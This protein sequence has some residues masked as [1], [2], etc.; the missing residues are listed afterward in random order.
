MNN[1][2][3]CLANLTGKERSQYVRQMFMQIAHSYDLMNR[4]ITAGQDVLW[5]QEVI[6]QAALPSYGRLLDLGT[7][8]GDLARE[9]LRQIPSC[10]VTAADFTLEMMNVGRSRTNQD[11]LF[12]VA[13]DAN[14]LPFTAATF[15]AV[16]SGFLLRNVN[17]VRLCLAEQYR[18]LKPGGRIVVLDTTPPPE[19]LLAPA[20]R[21]HLHK[22]I[23]FL[24]RL[25]TGQAE[26]YSYLPDSTE[27]FLQPEQLAVRMQAVG[28]RRVI[29]QRFMFGTV[30]IHWGQ[31]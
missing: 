19:N 6:R 12:W 30:A 29:F 10:F 20:I 26:A 16:V 25:L 15:D 1:T 4:L 31:K 17:D 7:C 13:A 11:N 22:V 18:V 23:P 24:G 28:F 5:R 3:G 8:T 9:A 2:E 21:I 14:C 27:G